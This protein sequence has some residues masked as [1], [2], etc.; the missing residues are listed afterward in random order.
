MKTNPQIAKCSELA[1]RNVE[2]RDMYFDV[3]VDTD[4]DSFIVKGVCLHGSL[5][6]L[7]DLMDNSAQA[8]FSRMVDSYNPNAEAKFERAMERAAGA[9]LGCPA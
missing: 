8:H 7:Y 6:D 1:F 4:D 2:F 3:Y 5:V 9:L